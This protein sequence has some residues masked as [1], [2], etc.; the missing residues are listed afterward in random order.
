MKDY[1]MAKGE[2]VLTRIV[3]EHYDK[4]Y[5]VETP[6]S[7]SNL[8]DDLLDLTYATLLMAGY[9]KDTINGSLVELA[10]ER[11]YKKDEEDI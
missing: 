10:E 1:F 11:G 8:L 4:R 5:I 7:D 9:Q 6:Y 2:E 3:I